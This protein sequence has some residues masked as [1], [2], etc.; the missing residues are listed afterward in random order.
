VV[1]KEESKDVSRNFLFTLTYLEAKTTW[2]FCQ[3]L[4]AS[5]QDTGLNFYLSTLRLGSHTNG[6]LSERDGWMRR[7]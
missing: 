2:S 3:V 6:Q 4:I 5:E 1:Q 7:I